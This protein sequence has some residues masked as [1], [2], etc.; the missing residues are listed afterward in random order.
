MLYMVH[1]YV[2]LG[3][4]MSWDEVNFVYTRNDALAT[5]QGHFSESDSA[6]YFVD[7]LHGLAY[8]HM[9][10]ICH[11]D[12]KPENILLAGDGHC[13]ISDFG[14]S[15]MFDSDHKEEELVEPKSPTSPTNSHSA[16]KLKNMASQGE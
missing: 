10:N 13:K 5:D 7:I 3:G 12:L 1:E 9:H 6:H 8:L 15:H 11:R 2:P 16:R 4:I 14:V